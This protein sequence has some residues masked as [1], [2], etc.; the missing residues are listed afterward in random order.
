MSSDRNDEIQRMFE[1]M[2]LGSLE[3][4]KR[5]TDFAGAPTGC[6]GEDDEAACEQVFYEQRDGTLE[7]GEI[8]NG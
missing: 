8:S 3:E 1:E 6:P 5:F 4:R 2:G 7:F